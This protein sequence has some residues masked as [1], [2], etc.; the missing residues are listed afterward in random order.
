MFHRLLL[1]V[2]AAL[3]VAFSAEVGSDRKR[4]PNVLMV[5][6]VGKLLWALCVGP[7]AFFLQ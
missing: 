5:P 4:L 2:V 6:L 3:A 7:V 1:V